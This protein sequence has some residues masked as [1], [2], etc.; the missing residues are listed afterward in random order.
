M[1]KRILALFVTLLLVGVNCGCRYNDEEKYN[2]ILKVF[3]SF[4]N[5]PGIA[6]IAIRPDVS[7]YDHELNANNLQFKG[8]FYMWLCSFDGKL[9]FVTKQECSAFNT[10][11]YIY[12]CDYDGGN[13]T[14]VFTRGGYYIGPGC[15][16]LDYTNGVIYLEHQERIFG[17]DIIDSYEIETG[18]YKE[19]IATGMSFYRYKKDVLG[20]DIHDH[21]L[22]I[23]NKLTVDVSKELLAATEEGRAF[24]K[25]KPKLNLPHINFLNGRT[26][27]SY[28]AN[29]GHLGNYLFATFEY[30]EEKNELNYYCYNILGDN[31]GIQTIF[32]Y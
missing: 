27:V 2:E 32:L 25:Y 19:E 6:F 3:S 9:Y 12:R 30:D 14:E 11:I 8:E 15:R 23:E 22:E 20:Y 26:F 17:D 31:E 24:M 18:E 4:D 1:R 5:K 29:A 16:Y 28:Y 13:L 10:K 7:F 21:Y